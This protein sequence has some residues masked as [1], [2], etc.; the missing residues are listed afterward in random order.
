CC[1]LGLTPRYPGTV[2]PPDVIHRVLRAPF[3][4]Q[5]SAVAGQNQT[6]PV[7]AQTRP[8]GHQA[9]AT[10]L[11]EIRPAV[12]DHLSL[13]SEHRGAPSRLR[14]SRQTADGLGSRSPATATKKHKAPPDAAALSPSI[15][16]ST[17]HPMARVAPM[18]V[19]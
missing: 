16:R 18:L 13:R 2:V 1:S 14:R 3:S 11:P 10:P 17:P 5:E 12:P 6:R 8:S 19:P 9:P 15:E 7:Q 4:D